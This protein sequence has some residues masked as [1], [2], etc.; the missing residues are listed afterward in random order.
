MKKK[1]YSSTRLHDE[2][3]ISEIVTIHYYEFS[4]DY[5]F[6][7]EAHAFWELVYI[8]NGELAAMS[9]D[10][11]HKIKKG[12]LILHRPNEWHTLYA[13]GTNAA[14]AIII[15]FKCSAKALLGLCGRVFYTGNSE[16]NL[17]SDIIKEAQNAF[18]TPLSSLVTPML[19]RK[20]QQ[21]FGAEQL[22][23]IN[24]CRL[25]IG[26]V[27]EEISPARATTKANL[28]DGLFGEIT[29]FL[30]KNLDKKL[31]LEEI[32]HHAGISKT[33]LKQLFHEKVGGGVCEYFTDLKIDRAKTYIRESNFNFTQIAEML[34]YNTVHYFSAQFKTKVNM[35]PTEYASSIRALT[36][37]AE[38]FDSKSVK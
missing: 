20:K 15:S 32:A 37:E 19:H 25:L 1:M 5:R 33:A 14:S 24:L 12:G 26:L 9:E 34:G 38:R 3:A 6:P 36:G 4:K 22:I 31:S 35:S 8:D 13:D 11:E 17:L 27:R 23:K 16:R 2:I 21:L 18:D 28:N 10:T 30:E 29:D 7:G